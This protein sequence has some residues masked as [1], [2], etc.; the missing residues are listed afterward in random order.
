M[1]EMAIKMGWGDLKPLTRRTSTPQEGNPLIDQ[2][3]DSWKGRMSLKLVCNF[4]PT[5]EPAMRKALSNLCAVAH[6]LEEERVKPKSG[7]MFL[8]VT[9]SPTASTY[10]VKAS[11]D[12]TTFDIVVPVYADY[13]QDGLTSAFA[14][15][16]GSLH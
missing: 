10:S 11:S 9:A 5:G 12:G 13:S 8:T 1:V 15:C 14:K 7:K 2:M 6:P 4:K 16:A 3:I